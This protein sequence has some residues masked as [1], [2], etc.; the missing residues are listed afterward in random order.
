M[1]QSRSD[2]IKSE[3]ASLRRSVDKC[4]SDHKIVTGMIE[5]LTRDKF[6]IEKER[7]DLLWMIVTRDDELKRISET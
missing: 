5:N 1:K 4:D 7:T 3:I 2:I 6:G